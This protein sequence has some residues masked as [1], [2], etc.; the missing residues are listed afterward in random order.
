MRS[1]KPSDRLEFLTNPHIFSCFNRGALVREPYV[2]LTVFV[3]RMVDVEAP[4][5][6]FADGHIAA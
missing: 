3:L 2:A 4:K 6:T 1:Q 5:A